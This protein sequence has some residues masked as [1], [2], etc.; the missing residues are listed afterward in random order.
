MD[1]SFDVKRVKV[2]LKYRLLDHVVKASTKIKEDG[3]DSRDWASHDMMLDNAQALN[4]RIS[5]LPHVYYLSAACD[6]TVAGENGTRV[7][8]LSL[9]DPLFVRKGTL[10]GCYSGTTKAGFVVDDSWHANDGLVNTASAHAP[11]GAPQKPLDRDHIERGVWNVMPDVHADHG[12]FQG[13]FIKKQD[14]HQ[15]FRDLREL[16]LSLDL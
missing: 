3:R 13:G 14:P 6:A 15:Y 10:M 12:F 11:I 8:D 2:P 7:P 9:M 16:L 4:A 5:T 1:E